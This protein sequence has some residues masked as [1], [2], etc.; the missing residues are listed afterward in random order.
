MQSSCS[1]E[2]AG[3]KG[4][5]RCSWLL[6]SLPGLSSACPVLEFAADFPP[7][8]QRSV[9]CVTSVIGHLFQLEFDGRLP[10][11]LAQIY[12]APVVK[13][14]TDSARKARVADHLQELAQ[15]SSQ[16]CLWL[17]ADREGENIGFEVIAVCKEW[18]PDN[19]NV[20]RA[21]FS[22]LTREEVAASFKALG[23]PDMAVAQGVDA[24]QELDLRVGISFSTLLTRQLKDTRLGSVQRG[25]TR[26]ITYGPC[27][28][29]ALGFCVQRQRDIDS[30]QPQKLW[31]S[32]VE[33]RHRQGGSLK[34]V[35][36]EGRTDN[37]K[38][39]AA[40]KQTFLRNRVARV[41]SSS[42]SS[43]VLH[44]PTGLNTVQLL[45]SASNALNLGPKQAMKVAEDLYSAGII[46]YPRTETTRYHETFDAEASLRPLSRHP[47]LGRAAVRALGAWRSLAGKAQSYR[48]RD[49]GDHP[50]IVPLR[51][52]ASEELR[53]GAAK[54][55]YD[56][57][58]RH[59]LASWLGD[60]QLER[61]EACFSIG[62]FDFEVVL[63]R[64]PRDR[65]WLQAMPWRIDELCLEDG[66]K[67]LDCLE[68]LVNQGTADI[69]NW[70]LEESWTAP[71][72]PLT[73]AELVDLMDRN[74]IGTDASI[75]Q[76]IQT[77][78]DRGYVQLCDGSG[79]PIEVMKVGA[80]GRKRGRPSQRPKAPGRYLVPT[81]RGMALVR[82]LSHLDASLCEPE[83][84]ALI[85]RECA[86]VA[87]AE[88]LQAEV[89]KRNVDLFR[90]KF[91]H[92]QH[93]IHELR[94]FFQA[95]G[96]SRQRNAR[97]K[98]E[99]NR[100]NRSRR[101]KRFASEA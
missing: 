77:I 15:G 68:Q 12:E 24:R 64:L 21:I 93:S 18:F 41:K 39:A 65:G 32:Q 11:Q 59:F 37:E 89:L 55:L 57:V 58:C 70:N 98:G 67:R 44:R 80:F 97:L 74:G 95:P 63:R 7:T 19:S 75:P 43:E 92:V 30:F 1:S 79:A 48:A 90:G 42:S 40:M 10:Q 3:E 99:A 5:R 14:F 46:S 28:T 66:T 72:L 60:V 87:R 69:S 86:M 9:I 4:F 88:L 71:P 6:R 13:T 62:D 52:A 22:A 35:W 73:E 85:E 23:R 81:E 27:Q 96:G 50:P 2:I 49:V 16:L 100:K 31:T 45:R 20:H 56:F 17:D 83:V 94:T 26:S 34:L 54:R 47:A 53:S 82:G 38:Q 61:R 25:V 8:G 84:R 76:H 91:Q 78:Q 29:P 36:K 101:Q 51:V 33:L